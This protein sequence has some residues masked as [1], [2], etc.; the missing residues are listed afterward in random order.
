MSIISSR[1]SCVNQASTSAKST[2]YWQVT[3][4]G[5]SSQISMIDSYKNPPR[6]ITQQF[7][8]DLVLVKLAFH[9]NR[10]SSVSGSFGRRASG[11]GGTSR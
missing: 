7:I 2:L 3:L 6:V 10:S 9:R 1:T 5:F 11:P 8:F 4:G